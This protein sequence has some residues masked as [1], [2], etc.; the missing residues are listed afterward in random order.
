MAICTAWGKSCT[1]SSFTMDHNAA[2]RA[3]GSDV[4]SLTDIPDREGI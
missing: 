1:S 4:N 2:D 3:D